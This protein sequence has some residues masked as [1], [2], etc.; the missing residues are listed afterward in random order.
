MKILLKIFSLTLFVLAGLCVDCVHA[1]SQKVKAFNGRITGDAVATR[2]FLDFS[3]SVSAQTFYSENPYRIVID[4]SEVEF[5]DEL[6]SQLTPSGLISDI[7]IG[8]ISKGRSR[9][10]LTLEQPAEI[11]QASMKK[12]I[13]E[14]F[15]RFLLDMEVTGAERFAKLLNAQTLTLGESGSV[16]PKGDRVTNPKKKDGRFTIV[17]D[18]GHGGIDSG[19]VG[20]SGT[21]EKKI[22]LAFSLLLSEMIEAVGPFDVELTRLDDTFLPLRQRV[23]FSRRKQA[24][25]FIS[26]HADSLNDRSVRGSTVYTLSKRASDRLSEA[27]AQSE[28]QADLA[29][30]LEIEEDNQAVADILIDLT[31]RET[32]IL[33][34]KFSQILAVNLGDEIRLNKNPERSAAFAVLKAPDVPGVLLELGYLSN[35]EDEKLLNSKVWR[36]KAARAVT[37]AVDA[38]FKPRL[39][40]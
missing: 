10:V 32:K 4:I 5:S 27:L 13:D 15:H 17:L 40:E 31:T 14:E 19:A 21:Q 34:K 9:I 36:E 33:S 29:G 22:V 11:V 16:A 12:V 37:R 28:N 18:P 26:V 25:L 2:F 38:Y 24:D 20:R 7:Q 30:G 39:V 35:S 23:N 6:R 3:Q 8:R 1:Q